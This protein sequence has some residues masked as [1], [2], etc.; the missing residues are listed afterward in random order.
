[1]KNFNV[2][3]CGNLEVYYIRSNN[4]SF[5]MKPRIL[6]IVS[7]DL[8]LYGMILVNYLYHVSSFVLQKLHLYFLN[9][10]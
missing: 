7:R 2:L 8:R 4:I 3:K 5:G 1:M 6:P 10:A 9:K